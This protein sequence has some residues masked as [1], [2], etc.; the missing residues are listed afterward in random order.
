MSGHCSRRA[1]V[2]AQ[3]TS[4]ALR[5]IDLIL[6]DEGSQYEDTEFER[7]FTSIREQPHKP[8]TVIVADFQQLQPVG[9]GMQCK[10]YCEQ[11]QTVELK[12]VYRTEDED[13]LVFLNSTRD[14]QPFR[15][16]LTEYFGN[17]FWHKRHHSLRSCVAAGMSMAESAGFPF[18]WLTCTNRGASDVCEVALELAGIRRVQ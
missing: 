4:S 17:R 2:Q 8:F 1:A 15:E 14:S 16:K 3:W 7:L 13:H 10:H 5:R 6:C 18:I 9:S 11:T 12:T